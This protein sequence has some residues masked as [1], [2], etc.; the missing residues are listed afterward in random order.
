MNKTNDLGDNKELV[1][2]SLNK[3]FSKDMQPSNIFARMEC[4]SVTIYLTRILDF[5]GGSP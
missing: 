2:I 4:S 5:K 3:E 1:F